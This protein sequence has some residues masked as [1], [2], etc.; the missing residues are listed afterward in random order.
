MAEI[1]LIIVL[2]FF[3]LMSL[4]KYKTIFNGSSLGCVV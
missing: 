4:K 1:M 3:L 2:V